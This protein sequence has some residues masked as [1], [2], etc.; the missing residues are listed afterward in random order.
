M[1]KTGSYKKLGAIEYF[2]PDALPPKDPVLEV[3]AEMMTLYGEASAALSK[4]NEMA[5]HVP[6]VERFLKAYSIK[7]AL[8]S[9]SIEG[10]HTTLL[11]VFT[12]P[13]VSSKPSKN[14]QLVLNYAKALESAIVLMK[15]QGLPLVNRVILAA[16]KE[17]MTCGDG[18]KA[19]PGNYRKQ[20]VSVGRLVPP[21]AQDVVD[22]MADL[23]KYINADSD[24]PPLIRAGL[25]HAQFETIHPFLDG[26]GR[27]GRLLIVLMLLEGNVLEVPILYPSYYFKK[28]HAEYYQRLNAIERE[29]DFEGWICYFLKTIKESSADAYARAKDIQALDE[30]YAEMIRSDVNF[31][32]VKETALQALSIMF[33][34]PVIGISELA[35]KMGK[36]YNTA[37]KL[38]LL[39]VRKGI[40]HAETND[41]KRNKLYRFDAYLKLLEKEY[42]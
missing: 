40:L 5:G 2:I 32:K 23:E 26:N 39:F 14:T 11:D 18:D 16:H 30:H 34:M 17:L 15:D 20:S 42:A 19:S 41:Q 27:V 6:N 37:A 31:I 33:T 21:P 3:N 1:R 7:E 4:L 28:H 10:I 29:G 36:S 8:L 9:S 38:C 24:L 22:L 12:Q 35:Q 25:V 13:L